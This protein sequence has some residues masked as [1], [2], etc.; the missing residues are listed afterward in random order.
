MA[1]HGWR[2]GAFKSDTVGIAHAEQVGVAKVLSVG[3]SYTTQVGQTRLEMDKMGT[4]AIE[5]AV[6]VLIKGGGAAQLTVGPG[7]VLYAP[8]LVPGASPLPP[9]MCLKRM[10]ATGAPF[11]RN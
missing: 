10:A 9:A 5:G 11:V 2:I 7:P 6:N 8:A 1:S 3:Q 4:V